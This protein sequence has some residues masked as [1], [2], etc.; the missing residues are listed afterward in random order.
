MTDRRIAVLGAGNLGTA[1]VSG[2]LRSGGTGAEQIV[3]TVARPERA[4]ELSRR[5]GIRVRA[6]GNR[7][8]AQWA[9]L[10]ILAVKPRWMAPVLDEIQ[11]AVTDE[12]IVV[13]L[14]AA[15][16]IAAIE[17][18]LGESVPVFRVMMNVAVQVTEAAAAVCWN[19]AARDEHRQQVDSL[20]R[21]VGITCPVEESQLHA[22]TALAGSGPAFLYTV[23]EALMAGALKAGMGAEA[24][25]VLTQQTMLGTARLARET[26][27][28]PA[29]LRDQVIT[30]GGTTI[31]GLH[32]LE[33]GAVRAAFVSAVEAATNRSREI[34][35]QL[36]KEAHS[37]HNNQR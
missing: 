25:R 28:H 32:E 29:V 17:Q 4:E 27:Q 19:R 34:E 33:R 7:E 1:L 31:A 23:M 30:P 36:A 3:A 8:A 11:P 18:V 14:A 5:L 15:F 13:S 20:F 6:G 37:S 22:V 2:L 24:A 10:I 9:G 26:G 16:P 12:K 21:S 35:Q